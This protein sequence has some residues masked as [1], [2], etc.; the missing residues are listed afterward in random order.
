M[1]F[2]EKTIPIKRLAANTGQVEGVPANP[3]KISKNEM[4][5][6]KKSLMDFPDMLKLRELVV[7][8]CGD[9]FV[10]LGGNQRLAAAKA[11]GFEDMPCKVLAADTPAEVMREFVIKD[12]QQRGEDDWELLQDWDKGELEEW[13][14]ELKK[15][16]GEEKEDNVVYDSP[17]QLFPAQEY[18]LITCADGF[19]FDAAREHFGLGYVKKN[20]V[21]S[22]GRITKARTLKWSDYVSSN[23]FKRETGKINE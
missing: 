23:T 20:N 1:N 15:G 8:P 16:E 9:V 13:G 17:I 5:K 11:V 19:E 3:R 7:V 14:V 2:E 21:R 18:I 6:L 10:V 22:G 12:N 4:A